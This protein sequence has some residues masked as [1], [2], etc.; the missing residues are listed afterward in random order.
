MLGLA[1]L[2]GLT[3][4]SALGG[5]LTRG[6]MMSGFLS[7][8]EMESLLAGAVKTT[9][10]AGGTAGDHTITGIATGDALR[11]V[12]QLDFTLDEGSPNTRTWAPADLTSEF[13]V[14][15]ADTTNNDG[16]TDTSDSVLVVVYEDLTP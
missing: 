6:M 13:S 7:K 2:E 15:A 4:Q 5:R 8:G 14:S 12:L 11:A 10:I 1:E 16:G 3:K 9:V